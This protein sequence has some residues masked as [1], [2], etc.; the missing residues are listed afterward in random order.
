MRIEYG[1]KEEESLGNKRSDLKEERN[2]ALVTLD[3]TW[4]GLDA[5]I[6]WQLWH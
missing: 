6:P 4:A 1:T 5:E 2:N 3:V